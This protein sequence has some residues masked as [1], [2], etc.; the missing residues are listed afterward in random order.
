[1]TGFNAARDPLR[2][3]SD[4]AARAGNGSAGRAVTASQRAK[5]CVRASRPG[6]VGD[7]VR[8]AGNRRESSPSIS[9]RNSASSLS[10]RNRDC[11]QPEFHRRVAGRRPFGTLLALPR[12]EAANSRSFRGPARPS[13]AGGGNRRRRSTQVCAD[14]CREQ[15][16]SGGPR[17]CASVPPA[18]EAEQ[19][20]P[21]RARINVGHSTSRTRK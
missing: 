10:N 9:S 7:P 19:P 15:C 5:A 1:M 8:R 14:A 3:R 17:R 12:H 2:K 21:P 16:R 18:D 11:A 20:L 4:S 6:R 13:T